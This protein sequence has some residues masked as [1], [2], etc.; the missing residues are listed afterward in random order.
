MVRFINPAYEI[1]LWVLVVALEELAAGIV[2]VVCHLA[3]WIPYY[4]LRPILLFT[5]TYV[6]TTK[7]CS[8]AST[9]AKS[10]MGRREY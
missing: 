7:M 4:S 9:L 10:I 3:T 8:D 6:S 2:V 5:N 1:A